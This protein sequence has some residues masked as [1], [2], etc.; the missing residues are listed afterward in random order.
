MSKNHDITLTSEYLKMLAYSLRN[1]F[2]II[3]SIKKNIDDII[4]KRKPLSDY[5]ED[6]M[7]MH[8]NA[9]QVINGILVFCCENRKILQENYRFQMLILTDR[10]LIFAEF[11]P[12]GITCHLKI[13]SRIP[14][15]KLQFYFKT[16]M[17]QLHQDAYNRYE[18]LIK[19]IKNHY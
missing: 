17:N 11:L 14:V 19:R 8:N 3:E 6:L 13:L 5:A 4:H 16:P 12:S 15:L 1:Q 2:N 18:T 10:L 7:L 9:L